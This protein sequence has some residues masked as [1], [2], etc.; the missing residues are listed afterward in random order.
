MR[1]RRCEPRRRKLENLLVLPSAV[2]APQ[3]VPG[4]TLVACLL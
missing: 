1:G 4:V 2:A 3:A